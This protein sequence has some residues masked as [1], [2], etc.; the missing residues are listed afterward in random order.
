MHL[1]LIFRGK[2]RMPVLSHGRKK[3]RKKQNALTLDTS[4]TFAIIS[5]VSEA[6][7]KSEEYMAAGLASLDRRRATLQV[8]SD[9]FF[10]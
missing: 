6:R 10:T 5:A 3:E 4:Q 7:F 2:N 8:S 9:F 1:F